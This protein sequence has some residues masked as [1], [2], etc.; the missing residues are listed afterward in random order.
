MVLLGGAF[1]VTE[2]YQSIETWSVEFDDPPTP[3]LVSVLE[4]RAER[5]RAVLAW[6]VGAALE[7]TIQ[8]HRPG[9]GWL[10]VAVVRSE[11]RVLRWI[12]EALPPE[13]RVG[14]RLRL[15][16]AAAAVGEAWLDLPTGAALDLRPSGR[17]TANGGIGFRIR[18]PDPADGDL[19]IFDVT[20]RRVERIPLRGLG[21][22]THDL[23]VGPLAPGL[24]W[25][26]LRHRG[27]VRV[28]RAAA[29]R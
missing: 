21:E 2:P 18:L 13:R 27:A 9:P 28:T 4:A 8:R 26:R 1:P 10:D 19:S 25:G 5:D 17:R 14:Y 29:L 11:G 20:G 12:D 3:T 15:P 23:E 16:G 6:D 24:Y 22:G 7:A